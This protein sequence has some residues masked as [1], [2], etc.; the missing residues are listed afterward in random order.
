MCA[1]AKVVGGALRISRDVTADWEL[2]SW[3]F[4]KLKCKISTNMS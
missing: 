3:A 2:L 4:G 1:T